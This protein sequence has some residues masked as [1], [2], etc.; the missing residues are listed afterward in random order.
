MRIKN[1]K[2][3]IKMEINKGKMIEN[4]QR[5]INKI[6]RQRINKKLIISRKEFKY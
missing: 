1:I 2:K 6:I 4:H 5:K 3:K